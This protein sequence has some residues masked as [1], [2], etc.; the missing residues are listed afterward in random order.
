MLLRGEAFRI[1]SKDAWRRAAI[2]D[3]DSGLSPIDP[4]GRDARAC[5]GP[6]WPTRAA[7]SA[8]PGRSLL[9]V[10]GR[11]PP[12][13]GGRESSRGELNPAVLVRV[14]IRIP[15]GGGVGVWLTDVGAAATPCTGG[16]RG[17]GTAGVL[18]RAL[19]CA[20]FFLSCRRR[21]LTCLR[22]PGISGRRLRS[23]RDPVVRS[24]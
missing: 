5:V 24:E 3:G 20:L 6:P 11:V 16:I 10:V 2:S 8:D 21:A 4:N 1:V 19:I 9:G 15:P 22:M 17:V 13:D 12:D 14:T 18:R 7:P 23:S